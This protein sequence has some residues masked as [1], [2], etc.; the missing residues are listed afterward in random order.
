MKKLIVLMGLLLSFSAFA[1]ETLVDEIQAVEYR[2]SQNDVT[3]DMSVADALE[4]VAIAKKLELRK[5]TPVQLQ[6][7][8]QA[9]SVLSKSAIESANGKCCTYG[10]PASS[11][12]DKSGKNCVLL[13]T[14]GACSG[15]SDN[16]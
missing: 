12:T 7:V 10:W 11:C 1:D 13:Q 3:R 16:C 4:V 9:R 14:S 8:N 2:Q 15:T 6:L 5:M